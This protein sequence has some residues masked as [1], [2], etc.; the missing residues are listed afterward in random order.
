MLYEVITTEYEQIDQEQPYESETAVSEPESVQKPVQVSE[1]ESAPQKKKEVSSSGYTDWSPHGNYTPKQE[2]MMEEFQQQG[3][4]PREAE[5]LANAHRGPETFEQALTH[6]VR[7]SDISPKM[8]E[9]LK[10]L[11]GPWLS[12]ARKVSY[13]RAEA[14]KNPIK[15]AKGKTLKAHETAMGD[16]SSALKDWRNSDEVKAMSPRERY[17]AEREWKKQYHEQNPEHREQLT[18]YNFV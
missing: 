14:E 15:Y 4:S 9:E 2:K 1:K 11:T 7:P 8:M 16:Y 6:R 18:S 12:N 17:S 10:G 13:H 5:R 3:Y